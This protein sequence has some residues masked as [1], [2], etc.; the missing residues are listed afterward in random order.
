MIEL[1]NKSLK[2]LMLTVATAA[3]ASMTSLTAQAAE[4]PGIGKQVL[5]NAR[6]QPID[7]FVSELFGKIG[8]P[9]RV[10]E[11]I[12]GTVNGD[13]KKSAGEVIDE[14]SSAF[15]LAVYFDGAVAHVYPAN[16]IQRKV[17]YMSGGSASSVVKAAGQLGLTD[18]R[19]TVTATEVGLVATGAD[20]F[21]GQIDRLAA[22]VGK[23]PTSTAA[24]GLVAPTPEYDTYR[25]FKLKY[26]W[27]DDVSLV[28]G[29]DTVVVPGVA[30]LIRSLIEPGALGGVPT[31]R[32]T[33]G[34]TSLDGLRGQGLRGR[35]LQEVTNSLANDDD[36]PLPIVHTPSGGGSTAGT[37]IVADP[38]SN[39]V[40]IR[41]RADRMDNYDTLIQ[42]LDKEPQM[43]E[44]EATIIDLDTDKLREL[45]VNWRLTD[46][47]STALV[48]NVGSSLL[49]PENLVTPSGAG[50]I[51][52]LVLGSRA[53]FIS[54]IRALETQGAAR[55]VSKP[56]VMTLSNVEALLDTTSTFFV[57]VAGQE[58]VDLFDVKVGTRL[59]V[60]P[61]VYER[62]NRS[63]IKLRVNITDGTTSDQQVDS[64][65]V[66]DE[67]NI[68][69]QALIEVGQSLL[70][71]G[72]VREIKS[73][74]IS[75]VPILGRLPLVGGL[76]RTQTKTSTRH[77]R[78]FLI[79]PR[80]SAPHIPGKRFSA[81]V[82]AGT[83]SD[84][85]QSGPTRLRASTEALNL[86]EEVFPLEQNLPKGDGLIS[87]NTPM[88]Q[89]Y[90]P[91]G[92]EPSRAPFS[93]EIEVERTAP[94]SL[95]DR[96]Q[97]PEP[98][99]NPDD[100]VASRSQR[101]PGLIRVPTGELVRQPLPEFVERPAAPSAADNNSGSH[102]WQTLTAV[103]SASSVRTGQRPITDVVE[104]AVLVGG[105]DLIWQVVK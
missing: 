80:I 3:I 86:R 51:V 48:G 50:G 62:G 16:D 70:I 103:P 11:S 5:L 22:A 88:T 71:G 68:N 27:A 26:A 63:Q 41:D 24:A 54:R 32:R 65:P 67:S 47:D 46:G 100:V 55:I 33:P 99:V 52:S 77:E 7:L 76:F 44:I 61:H 19:N 96:L 56:H 78:L 95:R 89:P 42:E 60:T 28:I 40:I 90:Q 84:I 20:R 13:F 57:R 81:P 12:I 74:G 10:D 1:K 4:V 14:I 85:I 72:L 2:R 73:N 15:Q 18:R 35:G 36:A 98:I 102:G 34:S 38:L 94:D 75:R 97:G 91:M 83:E 82:L 105:D 64:I 8:V 93:E 17:M 21:I 45:G 6:E 92:Q 66:I 53:Q 104:P 43:V 87:S 79:T 101:A 30:S 69:T 49:S 29:G 23:G 31:S 25:I 9:A 59:R 58:E 37:R 39:S